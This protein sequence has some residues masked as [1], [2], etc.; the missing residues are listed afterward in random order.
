MKRFSK[1]AV[2]FFAVALLA[3]TLT[4][5]VFAKTEVDTIELRTQSALLIDCSGSMTEQEA[6]ESLLAQ[7]DQSAFDA[8]VYFDQRFTTDSDFTGGGNSAIC[9]AIDKTAK[10]GFEHIAVVTDGEQWP[11]NYS[12]L[13]IYT[14]IDLTIYLVEEDEEAK[15]FIEQLQSRLTNSNL[16]VVKPDGTEEMVL[17]DYQP[18]IYEIQINVPVIPEKNESE[19]HQNASEFDSNSNDHTTVIVDEEGRCFWW[20]ALILAVLIAALFDFIH[21]LITRKRNKDKNRANNTY[22]SAVTHAPE[23]KPMPVKAVVHIVQ[24]ANVVADF[25]GSM[26]AQQSETAK[27]CIA[28]KKDSEIVLCFGDKVSEHAVSELEGIKAAGQTAGWEALEVA[29]S[30]GWDEI[31][32]VSDLSFNGKAFNEKAFP[33][34]FKKVTVVTPSNYYTPTLENLKKIADEVEVL[35]L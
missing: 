24:G 35:P 16:K 7:I 4:V 18:P 30:K 19:I 34:K 28:A 1:A 6:V 9:E 27:A 10:G 29:A 2:V 21:E 23:P 20:V 14:D 8:V 25:S 26:A 11:Q 32:L 15:E 31:V 33:K 3:I 12:A 5:S 17:A 22:I 13:G